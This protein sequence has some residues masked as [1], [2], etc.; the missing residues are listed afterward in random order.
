MLGLAGCSQDGTASDP[1]DGSDSD[2]SPNGS[3]DGGGGGGGSGGSGCPQWSGLSPYDVAETD[4]AVV[5]SFPSGWTKYRENHLEKTV[6]VGYGWPE[7]ASS[8]SYPDLVILTQVTS[9]SEKDANSLFIESGVYEETDPLVIGGTELLVGLLERDD[10]AQWQFTA[11]GPND[12]YYLTN[13]QI[14]MDNE[15][16]YGTM[17]ELGR[18]VLDSLEPNTETTL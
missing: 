11:P 17:Y 14:A 7:S 15:D 16:C 1:D 8:A 5:P 10:G 6:E 2:D 3:T 4:F 12:T 13:F 18:T 9:P